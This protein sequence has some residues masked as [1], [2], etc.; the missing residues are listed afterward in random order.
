MPSFDF[1]ID[2]DDFLSSCDRG[3]IANVIEWL[4]EK[5]HINKPKVRM[6][7]NETRSVRQEFFQRSVIT[8]IHSYDSLTKEEEEMINQ[9]AKKYG[10]F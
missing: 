7:I 1:D 5:G 6:P 9:I 10:N 2:I 4:G 8:L 3:D